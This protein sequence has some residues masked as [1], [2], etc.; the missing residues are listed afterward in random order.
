M[1]KLSKKDDTIISHVY[2]VLFPSP[3]IQIGRMEKQEMNLMSSWG[4]W[5]M[6]CCKL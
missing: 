4:I 6:T 5:Q 1:S 2:L 3:S